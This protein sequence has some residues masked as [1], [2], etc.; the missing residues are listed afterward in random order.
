MRD[1]TFL[2]FFLILVVLWIWGEDIADCT[3][4]FWHD[5]M[6]VVHVICSLSS[7]SPRV[8]KAE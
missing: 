6:A 3:E 5:S 2:E 1:F 7:K 8:S 4:Y